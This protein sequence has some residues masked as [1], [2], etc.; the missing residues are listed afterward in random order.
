MS[1]TKL[2]CRID[3]CNNPVSLV[4]KQLCNMHHHRE[5]QGLPLVVPFCTFSNCTMQV[6]RFRTRCKDHENSCDYPKCTKPRYQRQR[7]C[8]MHHN[9]RHTKGDLGP[10][11]GIERYKGEWRQNKDG[12]FWRHKKGGGHEFQHRKVMEEHLGRSLLK[13]ETVHHINGDRKDNRIENLE[14]W[15]TSQPPGQRVEDKIKWAKEILK[16]YEEGVS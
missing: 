6:A 9:R 8:T 15:S 4:K 1:K 13:G 10:L 3:K 11:E 7:W 2:F 5:R 12:Y 16:I 14:L